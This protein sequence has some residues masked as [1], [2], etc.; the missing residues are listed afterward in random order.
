MG[1]V[2]TELSPG[3]SFQICIETWLFSISAL[4][5]PGRGSLR[6]GKFISVHG[7]APEW[8]AEGACG[9]C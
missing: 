9:G 7:S 8:L 5:M 3:L 2:L 1:R 4:Q 6:E